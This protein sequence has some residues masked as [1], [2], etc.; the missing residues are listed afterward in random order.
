MD[1]IK[2]QRATDIETIDLFNDG[3]ATIFKR[4]VRGKL[5]P[6]YQAKIKLPKRSAF[7]VS[8]GTKNQKLAE[9]KAR[10]IVREAEIRNL[11]NQPLQS[12]KFNDA[13]DSYIKLQRDKFKAREI[14]EITLQAR[15]YIINGIF[16]PYFANK[17]AHLVTASDITKFKAEVRSGGA[18]WN[19]GKEL[20][21][22]T[23]N[24]YNSV[25]KQIFSWLIEQGYITKAPT[26]KNL[27]AKSR[28]PSIT[29]GEAKHIQVKLDEYINKNMKIT[30]ITKGAIAYNH[31]LRMAVM[32]MQYGGLRPGKEISSIHWNGIEYKKLKNGKEY[33][34]IRVQTSKQKN[35]KIAYR[36]VVC[37]K[38]IKPYLEQYK[39]F[40]KPKNESEPLFKHPEDCFKPEL[41]G[42]PIGTMRLQWS[43]FLKFAK[44]PYKP[45][46]SI[47][48]YYFESRLKYGELTLNALAKNGGTSARVISDWYD[49]TLAED[50]AGSLSEVIDKA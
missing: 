14:T 45:F 48:H 41:R 27:N 10:E 36:K 5:N 37:M 7:R 1:K 30:S 38:E 31:M 16:K 4:Y 21:N 29:R 49:E 26:I 24:K 35:G 15:V 46:Y 44:L 23:L 40:Q 11:N 17:L 9:E 18:S 6:I 28:R 25:L 42:K 19:R 32:L 47:R 22:G 20:S 34:L 50:Y 3:R 39:K 33:V 13:C 12:I 2:N 8:L 43:K